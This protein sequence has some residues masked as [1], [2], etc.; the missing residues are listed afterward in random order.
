MLLIFGNFVTFYYHVFHSR[1]HLMCIQDRL[2]GD[3]LYFGGYNPSADA[4]ASYSAPLFSSFSVVLLIVFFGK[5]WLIALF[6]RWKATR[7]FRYVATVDLYLER[8]GIFHR[9]H[10]R[11]CTCV[12][13]QLRHSPSLCGFAIM[14]CLRSSN[15][16]ATM[17]CSVACCCLDI[18]WIISGFGNWADGTSLPPAERL[19]AL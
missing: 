19:V 9:R 10:F 8:Q 11:H 15:T 3:R 4:V 17:I 5:Q 18:R 1:Y 13:A 6:Q 2:F 7:L 12:G 16:S 14:Q